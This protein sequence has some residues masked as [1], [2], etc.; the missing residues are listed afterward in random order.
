MSEKEKEIMDATEEDFE[1]SFVTLVDED[2]TEREFEVLEILEVED[3]EY[4]VIAPP[5]GEEDE[6]EALVFRLV[7]DETTGEETLLDIESDEEW[8]KVAEIY[9]GMDEEE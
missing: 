1:T 9:M 7:T 6:D 2:G 5:E 3:K 4:V 8:D